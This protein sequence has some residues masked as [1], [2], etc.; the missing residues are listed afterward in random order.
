M[1]RFPRL[2]LTVSEYLA[3]DLD[4]SVLTLTFDLT[5]YANNM[6]EVSNSKNEIP[7]RSGYP[8]YLYTNLAN[9]LE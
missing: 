8:G 1:T 5:N 3:Y 6:R 9:L 2:A 7:G 4:Y